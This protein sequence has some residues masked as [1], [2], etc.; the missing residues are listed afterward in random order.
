LKCNYENW[1]AI[2][3]NDEAKTNHDFVISAAEY[4]DNEM[5]KLMLLMLVSYHFTYNM[6]LSS[7]RHTCV[8]SRFNLVPSWCPP[9]V[10]GVCRGLRPVIVAFVLFIIVLVRIDA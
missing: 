6:S 7:F 8:F 9:I 2:N 4:V 10:A 3:R 5:V 1:K